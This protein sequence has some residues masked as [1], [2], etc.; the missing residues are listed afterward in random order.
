M[1]IICNIVIILFFWMEQRPFERFIN[2]GCTGIAVADGAR[3]SA[4]R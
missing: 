4:W 3:G 1:T 2:E